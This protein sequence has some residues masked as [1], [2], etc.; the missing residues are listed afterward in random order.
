[1]IV[2]KTKTDTMFKNLF[3]YLLASTILFSCTEQSP[4]QTAVAEE[5]PTTAPK[6]TS[7]KVQ[8]LN[9]GTFHFGPT[10]DGNSTEFDENGTK[11]QQEIKHLDSLLARFKPTI[12]C[13]EITPE[14]EA[15]MNE[16]Y[17][18][19]LKNHEK[20]DANYGEVSLV[21]FEVGRM[22]GVDKIYGIDHKMNYNWNIGNE[23]E[24]ALDSTTYKAFTS[25]PIKDHP[26]LKLNIDGLPLME[27]IQMIN[28]PEFLDL[29]INFNAD[30]LTHVGSEN[31]FEGADE[32]AILYQRNLRMYSNINRIPATKDDRIFI[33]S[34][35]THTAFFREFMKRSPKYELVDVYEYL[36]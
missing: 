33:I 32:A 7:S 30:M 35:G 2:N 26:D 19:Y 20:M 13:V 4:V 28:R 36:N 11:E 16:H 14:S 3:P 23:M 21:A 24:N 25:N 27:Q 9:L 1:M 22:C 34:G 29:M 5:T 31:G 8:V 18:A 10:S 15:Q 6:P 12:I 17:Q